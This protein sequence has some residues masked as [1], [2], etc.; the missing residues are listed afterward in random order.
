MDMAQGFSRGTRYTSIPLPLLGPWLQDI[1]SLAEL[2]CTLR[3]LGLVQQ[4]RSQ[5]LW[6]TLAELIAD[7]ILL[8]GLAQEPGGAPDAIRTGIS[9]AVQRGTLIRIQQGH[10][11]PSHTLLFVNDDPGRRAAANI[12]PEA[13]KL[14][15]QELPE[16]EAGQARPN[17]FS[18]YEENIGTITPLLAEEMEEAERTHPWPW[19]QEA[20]REA[21]DHNRRNWR[22]IAR[23]LERWAVEGKDNGEP[24]RHS[25]ETDP[26]EYLRDYLRRHGHPSR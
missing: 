1:L 2:K 4:R 26:K 25:K 24:G 15:P 16:G 19:I 11:D 18:L 3:I 9:Q 10:E 12:L 21:V 13:S 17:I 14:H 7:P 23:I 8:N 6:V 5:R 20:F 22:Y